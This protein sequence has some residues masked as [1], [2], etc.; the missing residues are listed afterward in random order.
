MRRTCVLLAALA[1]APGLVGCA[2]YSSLF[3]KDG[4]KVYGGTRLD[5]TLISEAVAPDRDSDKTK[6]LESPVLA[7]E[8]CCG[9]CDLPLS[10]IADTITL[11]VTVPVAVSRLG[12]ESRAVEPSPGN[13]QGAAPAE[14]SAEEPSHR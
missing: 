5:A 4:C 9:L 14:P 7:W 12:T 8:A 3:G 11:P 1:A 6:R 13:E 10:V 2:S